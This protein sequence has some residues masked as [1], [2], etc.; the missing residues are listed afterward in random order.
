MSTAPPPMRPWDY[1]KALW[2]NVLV[3][4][5]CAGWLA[6]DLFAAGM[7]GWERVVFPAF[8]FTL[9]VWQV[10]WVA[11][12]SLRSYTRLRASSHAM[13][14]ARAKLIST[15]VRRGYPLDVILRVDAMVMD[16]APVD[17][18]LAVMAEHRPP[19]HFYN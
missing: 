16:E 19:R 1:V 7:H 4:A 11:P 10:G 17:D 9:L 3:C 5:W 15:L 13:G 8:F 14:E 18:V 12:R 6:F 2:L